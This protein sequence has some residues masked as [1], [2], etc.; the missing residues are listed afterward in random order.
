MTHSER[1]PIRRK[2]K[3]FTYIVEL[4]GADQP[5]WFCAPNRRAERRAM[6]A[7][8][9]V[10]LTARDASMRSPISVVICFVFVRG[11][12]ISERARRPSLGGL[13]MGP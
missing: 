9:T 3:A 13:A 5:V 8:R 11:G 12:V 6:T 10:L 4:T 7:S 2:V 1:I